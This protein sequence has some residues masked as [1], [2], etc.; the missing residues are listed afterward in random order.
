M[1]RQVFLQSLIQWGWIYAISRLGWSA[2]SQKSKTVNAWWQGHQALAT[3]LRQAE[4][5]PMMW[6][7]A[8]QT[9][10]QDIDLAEL[11]RLL[12]FEHLYA[13]QQLPKQGSKIFRV[14]TEAFGAQTVRL[15]PKIFANAKGT[16][17]VPHVHNQMVSA[18]LILAGRFHVRTFDRQFSEETHGHVL[19]KPHMDRILGPGDVSTMSDDR[20][21]GHWL[22]AQSERAFTLDIALTELPFSKPYANPGNAYSMIF[23]DPTGPLS[24]QGWIEAPILDYEIA[25]ARFGGSQ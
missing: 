20:H 5:D 18:H 13:Q 19:L 17:V 10:C 6:Q 3:A 24:A 22:V 14:Q 1:Q 11:L 23:V 8:V 12:D 7:D 16:A 15:A 25:M 9:L 2:E 4:T 21:N